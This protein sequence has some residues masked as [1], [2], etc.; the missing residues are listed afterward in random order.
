MCVLVCVCVCVCV[1][2]HVHMCVCICVHTCVCLLLIESVRAQ[3]V[4]ALRKVLQLYVFL[5][6]AN[7]SPAPELPVSVDMLSELNRINKQFYANDFQ[8]QD[9]LRGQFLRFFDAHTQYYA[10]VCY[11]NIQL[12][13]PFGPIAYVEEGAIV[14]EISNYFQSDLVDYFKQN[15]GYDVT[16]VHSFCVFLFIVVGVNSTQAPCLLCAR[17]LSPSLFTQLTLSPPHPLTSSPSHFLTHSCT[18]SLH[19]ARPPSVSVVRW[20]SNPQ[21]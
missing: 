9:D 14:F 1:C 16:Q 20:C 3:T 17:A 12:V 6:I 7:K 2:M 8:F 18:H 13:Q 11:S 19:R 15:H 21:H 10:P 4:D 5:D